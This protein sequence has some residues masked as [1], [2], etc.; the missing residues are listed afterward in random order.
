M[1]FNSIFIKWVADHFFVYSSCEILGS[2]DGNGE[3]FIEKLDSL[4][5]QI[6]LRSLY[7]HVF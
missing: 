4:L 6:M 2:N 3:I 7:V 1:I 5:I